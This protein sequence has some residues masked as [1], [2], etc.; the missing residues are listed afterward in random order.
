MSADPAKEWVLLVRKASNRGVGELSVSEAAIGVGVVLVNNDCAAS[1]LVGVGRA[2]IA[3]FGYCSASSSI[4]PSLG[5][6][7]ESQR[8]RDLM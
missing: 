1:V 7:L 2:R 4:S 3:V 6:Y 8:R 5:Y